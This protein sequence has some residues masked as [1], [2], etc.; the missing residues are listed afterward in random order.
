MALYKYLKK[1]HLDSFLTNGSIKIGSLYE[2]R[3]VEKYGSVIGDNSEGTYQTE[4]S[5]AG[6]YEIDLGRASPESNFF[7]QHILRNDQ[8]DSSIKI[9]MEDGAKI[10][11]STHSPNLYIY[12]VTSKYD[13]DVMR[14]FGCDSCLEINRPDIFFKAI[15]KKIRHKA[16]FESVVN[17]IYGSK[18]THYMQPHNVHPAIK[19]GLEYKY[20]NEVRA[21]W[22][23]KKEINSPL[24]IEAPKAIR[25]CNIFTP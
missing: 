1:E 20:Q 19:K 5:K 3:E 17:I 15:S 22:T 25:A 13:P 6:T 2:Y 18:N 21:I 9:V 16:E 23:P 24:Y 12:C 10:I 8:Q 7:R 14:E 4:L 11:A